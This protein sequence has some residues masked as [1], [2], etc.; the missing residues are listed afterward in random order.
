VFLDPVDEDGDPGV[1]PGVFG[2]ATSDPEGDDPDLNPLLAG[3]LEI[4]VFI[5][6]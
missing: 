3:V 4:Y 5:Q 1:D 6:F 2:F